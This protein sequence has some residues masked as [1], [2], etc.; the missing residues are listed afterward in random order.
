MVF[1]DTR[2][3][4]D[5]EVHVFLCPYTKT[6]QA[7]TINH[8]Q[9]RQTTTIQRQQSP[10]TMTMRGRMLLSLSKEQRREG[11]LFIQYIK[12]FIWRIDRDTAE[13]GKV[14]G[15]NG[16]YTI[17][18]S[19]N[20][21]LVLQHVLKVFHL[22][23][24]GCTQLAAVHSKYHHTTFHHSFNLINLCLRNLAPLHDVCHISKCKIRCREVNLSIQT[25]LQDLLA[26]SLLFPRKDYFQQDVCVKENIQHSLSLLSST[27]AANNGSASSSSFVNV[28]RFSFP[29]I[30]TSGDNGRLFRRTFA[31]TGLLVT[32]FSTFTGFMSLFAS[33][34]RSLFARVSPCKYVHK[35]FNATAVII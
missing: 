13:L 31:T 34:S 3:N 15:I 16:H 24:Q 26:S 18:L 14:I 12:Q 25:S 22:M 23:A 19:S 6:K 11:G 29:S 5:E 35:L 4:V 32:G 7:T 27:M 33:H 10:A 30:S 20:S 28:L 9:L 1:A 21:T 17:A 8:K 2:E